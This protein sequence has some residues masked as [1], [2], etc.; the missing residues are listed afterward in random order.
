MLNHRRVK[1]EYSASADGLFGKQA[2]LCSMDLES[3]HGHGLVAAIDN[4]IDLLDTTRTHVVELAR[5]FHLL[6]AI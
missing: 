2:A 5:F 6:C 3:G 4:V 1:V